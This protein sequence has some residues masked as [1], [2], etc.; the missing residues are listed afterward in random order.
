[1]SG[2]RNPLASGVGMS[3]LQVRCR[4]K[5]RVISRRVVPTR[6]H[7]RYLP[8]TPMSRVNSYQG[9]LILHKLRTRRYNFAARGGSGSAS[10]FGR[11]ALVRAGR[12]ENGPRG[13]ETSGAPIG[14]FDSPTHQSL[15]LVNRWTTFRLC[16]AA[17]LEILCSVECTVLRGKFRQGFGLRRIDCKMCGG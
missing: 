9:H 10:G 15:P 7:C 8:V 1:V 14:R 11:Q 12:R 5:P 6:T 4:Q 17:F 2:A 13:I 16:S 3:S